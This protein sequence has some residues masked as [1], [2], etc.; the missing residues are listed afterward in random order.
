MLYSLHSITA[1]AQLLFTVPWLDNSGHGY[2]CSHGA[3]RRRILPHVPG[4]QSGDL[5]TWPHPSWDVPLL[6]LNAGW[7]RGAHPFVLHKAVYK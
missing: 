4:R 3:G 2:A 6:A 1:P 5:L 7:A